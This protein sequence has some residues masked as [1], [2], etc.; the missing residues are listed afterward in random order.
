MTPEKRVENSILEYL[1]SKGIFCFKINTG[2]VFDPRK[3]IFR[4]NNNKHILKGVSDILGVL[5][6]GT[7]L[8]IE[9]KTDKTLTT[10]KTYPTKEQKEFIEKVNLHK[11]IGFVARSPKDVET[12]IVKI[13]GEKYKTLF[14]NTLDH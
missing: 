5:P 6:N 4:T 10:Q 2:G 11:G 14:H 13:L 7:F 8:A 3:K 12:V 1:K 9:V